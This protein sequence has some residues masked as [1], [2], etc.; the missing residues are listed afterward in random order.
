MEYKLDLTSELYN[1]GHATLSFDLWPAMTPYVTSKTI[2]LGAKKLRENPEK[3]QQP[4]VMAATRQ[5]HL[6]ITKLTK[7]PEK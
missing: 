2:K 5:L 3:R 6:L 1:V 7:G 4:E